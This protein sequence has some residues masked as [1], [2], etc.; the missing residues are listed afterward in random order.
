ML[1]MVALLLSS[2]AEIWR[3]SLH[4]NVGLNFWDYLQADTSAEHSTKHLPYN[5]AVTKAQEAYCSCSRI[6]RKAC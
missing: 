5:E 4:P 6:N 3:S 2:L 1:I